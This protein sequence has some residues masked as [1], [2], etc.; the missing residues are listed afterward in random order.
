M[1]QDRKLG[2][3]RDEMLISDSL[4][5]PGPQDPFKTIYVGRVRNRTLQKKVT[6]IKH[7]P[8]NLDAAYNP[9]ERVTKKQRW[10]EIENHFGRKNKRIF[11]EIPQA[12]LS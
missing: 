3:K 10:T 1:R 5:E 7:H 9:S 12:R 4:P 11:D 6:E 2:A 8:D